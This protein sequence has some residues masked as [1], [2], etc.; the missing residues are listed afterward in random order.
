VLDLVSRSCFDNNRK[1]T[2]SQFEVKN[3]DEELMTPV[4][5][6]QD[7]AGVKKK[8]LFWEDCFVLRGGPLTRHP[9]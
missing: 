7:A 1:F 4:Q 9:L 2:V 6:Q 5:F 3:L 8:Y